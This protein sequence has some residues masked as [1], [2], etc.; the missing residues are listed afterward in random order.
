MLRTGV[1]CAAWLLLTVSVTLAADVGDHV[2]FERA[3]QKFT[4]TIVAVRPGGTF[5]EVETQ[6]G[7]QTR[8]LILASKNVRVIPKPSIGGMRTW[9]DRTG[10]FRIEATLDSQAAFDVVLR[11][12]DGTLIKV[13]LDKLSDADQ[14]YVATLETSNANPFETGVIGSAPVASGGSSMSGSAGIQIPKGGGALTLASPTVFPRSGRLSVDTGSIPS[15]F[16][17]DPSPLDF[18]ALGTAAMEIPETEGRVS[19]GKP[20]FVSP[21]GTEL[22]YQVRSPGNSFGRD[23]PVAFTEIFFVDGQQRKIKSV[24]KIQGESAWLCSANPTTGDVLGAVMK[25]GEEKAQSLCVIAGVR[26]SSPRTVA[27]W[28]MF[29]NDEK[30]SDYVRY[31]K[32]LSNKVVIVVYDN[33]VR[34]FDYERGQEVWSVKA[35]SFNEPA[36]T[37][38]GKYAACVKDQSCTIIETKTGEQIGSIPVTIIGPVALG[39]SP[40]GNRLAV[41]SGNK[42]QV[43]HVSTAKEVYSH[44]ANVPLGFMGKQV[45]WLAND[46]LLLPTGILLDMQKDLVV[47]KYNLLNDGIDYTDAEHQ[48]LLAFQGKNRMTIVRLPHDAALAA[49]DADHSGLTALKAGDGVGIQ[50]NVSGPGVLQGEIRNWL[51]TA[52]TKSGYR[53]SGASPTQLIAS[54]RQEEPKTQEYRI[55]GRGFG[56]ESV[57]YTPYTSKVSIMQNG[58]AI[59]TRSVTT[60]LPHFLTSGKTLNDVARESERPNTDFFKNIEF[61]KQ[62]LK[63][64]FQSGFG[65]SNVSASGIVDTKKL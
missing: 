18:S 51:T 13:P 55:F 37:P 24:G 49:A 54:T 1:A 36:V 11:K 39:F 3:G 57:T 53:S 42:V 46:Q 15:S 43:F 14:E 25:P 48:G 50:A 58:K 38:G 35:Q 40:D 4:G 41:A 16:T 29:P 62:I 21:S 5:V 64:E 61:P 8:K 56:T 30:K 47:W 32:I 17:A 44:E 27:H 6:A 63:P 31:R 19:I 60:G 7:G 20:L 45:F 2:E 22:S 52:L 33:Q 9:S 59:W 12:T 28:R 65:A 34:A 10:K 23:K 26:E